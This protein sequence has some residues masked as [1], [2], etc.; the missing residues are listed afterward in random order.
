MIEIVKVIDER[1]WKPA[2]AAKALG[3]AQARISELRCGKMKE[4]SVDLLLKYLARLGKHVDISVRDD[5][6]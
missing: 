6:A 5:V 4:F 1:G 2:E 3:V